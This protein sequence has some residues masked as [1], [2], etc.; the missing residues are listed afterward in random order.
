MAGEASGVDSDDSGK[1]ALDNC[2]AALSL[3]PS[4]LPVPNQC[5]PVPCSL[6]TSHI[7]P[8]TQLRHVSASAL[9]FL[10]KI[11]PLG[12]LRWFLPWLLQ[13]FFAHIGMLFGYKPLLRE[14]M[15]AEEW[16]SA[17]VQERVGR[18]KGGKEL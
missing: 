3:R 12:P 7:I 14:Y 13:A 1:L 18:R 9:I 6:T 11:W 2:S 17:D 15:T 4:S 16:E 10:P 8:L 5:S